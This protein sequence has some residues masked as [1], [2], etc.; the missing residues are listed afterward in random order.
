MPDSRNKFS[1]FL[2]PDSGITSKLLFDNL[3]NYVLCA[4]LYG[5]SVWLS[6]GAPTAPVG[7]TSA[8][9]FFL[10]K[11]TTASLVSVLATAFTAIN[12]CQSIILFG[13]MMDAFFALI[14][15]V[16]DHIEKTPEKVLRWV[17]ALS[18]VVVVICFVVVVAILGGLGVWTALSLVIFSATKNLGV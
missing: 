3:R 6:R 9:L 10:T 16:A 12:L 2:L 1:T 11:D 15:P 4:S 5:L 17:K 13:R 7:F 14:D 18:L 8:N